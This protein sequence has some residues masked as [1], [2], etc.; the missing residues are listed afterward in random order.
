M[1]V[2]LIF[3]GENQRYRNSP[4]QPGYSGLIKATDCIYNWKYT[5]F[6]DLRNSA[7]DF[8]SIFVTYE[9][10]ILQN[11]IDEIRPIR[12]ITDGPPAQIG[13]LKTISDLLLEEKSNYDRIVILRFD[14]QYRIRITKWPKWDKTGVFLASRDVN[15]DQNRCYHDFLFMVDSH[16]VKHLSD[17]ILD[18]I[19]GDV[20]HNKIGSYL[21]HNNIPFELMHQH[22]Y[23]LLDHPLYALKHFEAEPELENPSPG[24]IIK[25]FE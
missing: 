4:H 2:L 23:H 14:L 15:W 6:D 9:S 18:A 16:A 5:L 10:P 13:H 7:I 20:Y 1:K 22:G 3:R 12:V 19:T 11:L 21:Y 17:A 24:I 25:T 8:D